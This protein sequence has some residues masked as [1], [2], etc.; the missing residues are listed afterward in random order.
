MQ[1]ST[2]ES[3]GATR[4]SPHGRRR[5]RLYSHVERHRRR[6]GIAGS[7]AVGCRDG[8]LDRARNQAGDRHSRHRTFR[9]RPRRHCSS[10][11]LACADR[12]RP[13][14]RPPRRC[15]APRRR[16]RSGYRSR[17]PQAGCWRRQ[18]VVGGGSGVLLE[19]PPPQAPSTNSAVTAS[20]WRHRSRN[21]IGFG[22]LMSFAPGAKRDCGQFGR[23]HQRVCCAASAQ[24]ALCTRIENHCQMQMVLNMRIL[25]R[26]LLVLGPALWRLLRGPM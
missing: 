20:P 1:G 14:R 4:A 13:R 2:S 3:A 19:P 17:R 15:S 11:R 22:R 16:P 7:G 12:W 5:G 24:L 25:P 8:D 9:M 26:F 6:L 21:G 10:I 18:V 23:V